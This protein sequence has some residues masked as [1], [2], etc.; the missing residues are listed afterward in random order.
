[1]KQEYRYRSQDGVS[2]I[3]ISDVPVE[4]SEALKKWIPKVETVSQSVPVQLVEAA[5]NDG[6][7]S[8]VSD[9][10]QS[11]NVELDSTFGVKR[12]KR[13]QKNLEKGNLNE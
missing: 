8:E 3:K 2:Y 4:F 1:M 10:S 13:K 9:G 6:S 5:L 11:E 7:Q 12:R